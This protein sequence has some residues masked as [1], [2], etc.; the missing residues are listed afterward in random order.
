MSKRTSPPE[1][2]IHCAHHNAGLCMHHR[3]PTNLYQDQETR[4]LAQTCE[5]IF[6]VFIVRKLW[7]EVSA[8]PARRL[9]DVDLRDPV[10]WLIWQWQDANK[11]FLCF[12]SVIRNS[13]GFGAI[14][15]FTPDCG[16]V[17][18]SV[19][20]TTCEVKIREF[21]WSEDREVQGVWDLALVVLM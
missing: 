14:L 17:D 3:F 9:R 21:L 6:F 10:S 7:Q 19:T 1:Y 16:Y 13:R 11:I 4:W 20:Q 5:F 15:I 8:C 18:S 2:C 12:N